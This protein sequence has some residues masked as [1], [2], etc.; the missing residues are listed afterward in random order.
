MESTKQKTFENPKTIRAIAAQLYVAKGLSRK[1]AKM[2]KFIRNNR[3]YF[4]SISES[5]IKALMVEHNLTEDD[6]SNEEV[7]K[8]A[9][10]DLEEK[11]VTKMSQNSSK[12]DESVKLNYKV[13]LKQE[14][15]LPVD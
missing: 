1:P 4:P 12:E 14:E 15:F 9:D 13:N 5:N 3:D 2:I 7:V 6:I 8:F 10:L 11:E